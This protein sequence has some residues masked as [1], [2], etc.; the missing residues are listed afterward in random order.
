MT[1]AHNGDRITVTMPARGSVSVARSGAQGPPGPQ[2][3]PGA[4]GPQGPPGA[5]GPPGPGGVPLVVGLD[6]AAAWQNTYTTR[7]NA[8]LTARPF[9]VGRPCTVDRLSVYVNTAGSAEAA[10]TLALYADNGD[11]TASLIVEAG[12]VPADTTGIQAVTFAP[13]AVPAGWL[14]PSVICRYT[15]TAPWLAGWTPGGVNA[16]GPIPQGH[17]FFNGWSS[18]FVEMVSPRDLPQSLPLNEADTVLM[19]TF[20]IAS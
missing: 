14:L 12:T 2:G 16:D 19:T 8:M 9:L 20:R 11:G 3:P 6:Y 15:T 7:P 18:N 5:Q 4:T 1:T 10:I 13:V 17:G